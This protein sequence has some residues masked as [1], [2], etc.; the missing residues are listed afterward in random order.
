AL[1]GSVLMVNDAG[2]IVDGCVLY[3]G[4]VAPLRVRGREALVEQGLAG[5]VLRTRKPILI[6]N[7]NEDQRWL[8]REWDERP[9]ARAAMGVPMVDTDRVVGVLTLARPEPQPFT[10]ADV[11]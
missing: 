10:E 4:E 8:R 2:H 5:Y 6:N 9:Q 11:A 7:T 1:S 3:D